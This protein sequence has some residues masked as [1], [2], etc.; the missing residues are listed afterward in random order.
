[1]DD[2]AGDISSSGSSPR[3]ESREGSSSVNPYHEIVKKVSA[4]IAE[5]EDL[6]CG[7]NGRRLL[8]GWRPLDQMTGGLAP[9]KLW[10]V[11]SLPGVGKTTL[12]SNLV[13]KLCLR[14]RVSS[15]IHL[16]DGGVRDLVFRMVCGSGGFPL[17][18]L[19]RHGRFVDRPT[20]SQ[21]LQVKIFA[22]SMRDSPLIL[23]D[24]VALNSR[25][26]RRRAAEAANFRPLEWIAIDDLNRFKNSKSPEIRD[27]GIS[28]EELKNLACELQIPILLS[29]AMR[30]GADVMAA[31]RSLFLSDICDA[32]EVE[33]HAD[34]VCILGDASADEGFYWSTPNYGNNRRALDVVRNRSGGTGRIGMELC[35]DT[36]RF[37]AVPLIATT[38]FVEEEREILTFL[39]EREDQAELN[40]WFAEEELDWPEAMT[41][42]DEIP[43]AIDHT[44]ASWT[45]RE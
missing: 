21:L 24:S 45:C 7:D 33:K 25:N 30:N 42:R 32:T 19:A 39:R 6:L 15:L 13:E 26:L 3:K 17:N 2:D 18:E 38:H 10:V 12:L 31:G 5:I 35:H 4:C 37:N 22:E 16:Y 9:G 34:V 20:R 1:M 44:A 29:T 27:A 28:L 43:R 8:T 41:G 23:E 14:D 36:L 40:E 11:A